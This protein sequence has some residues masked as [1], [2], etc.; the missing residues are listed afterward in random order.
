V[1]NWYGGAAGQANVR[2][3]IAESADYVLWDVNVPNSP[4]VSGKVAVNGA[5]MEFYSDDGSVNRFPWSV[6]ETP[7]GEL[8]HVGVYHYLRE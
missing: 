8:L 4:P 7:R 6:E 2:L 1:G 3:R 5:I